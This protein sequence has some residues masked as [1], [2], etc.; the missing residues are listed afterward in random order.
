MKEVVSKAGGPSQIEALADELS[1]RD[2]HVTLAPDGNNELMLEVVNARLDFMGAAVRAGQVYWRDG[3]F[4]WSRLAEP[5]LP[6]GYRQCGRA[7]HR[8]VAMVES[9]RCLD[10][11]VIARRQLSHRPGGSAPCL[12]PIPL[13]RLTGASP[14]HRTT[15]GYPLPRCAHPRSQGGSQDRALLK[16]ARGAAAPPSSSPAQRRGVPGRGAAEAA[17]PHGAITEGDK[18]RT[19]RRSI[20]WTVTTSAGSSVASS[21]RRA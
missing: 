21:A 20:R 18:R 10:A 2:L 17:A 16:S 13:R 1:L 4:W 11:S 6:A 15:A 5:E 19:I 9:V 3:A 12:G 7:H 14:G 8:V